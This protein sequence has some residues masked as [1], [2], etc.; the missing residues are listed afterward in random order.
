MTDVYKKG[1]SPAVYLFFICFGRG[2][3]VARRDHGGGLALSESSRCYCRS[4]YDAEITRNRQ[5]RQHITEDLPDAS[6][7]YDWNIYIYIYIYMCVCVC[8]CVCVAFFSIYV[9]MIHV[10]FNFS[11]NR[12]TSGQK[13]STMTDTNC[14]TTHVF[15][16]K[17]INF[18]LCL[19]W[20]MR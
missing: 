16:R 17:I 1:R 14:N 4:W 6:K 13:V 5:W 20:H 3:S 9:C 7:M 18:F 12:N 11:L 15:A 8:V 19:K 2:T 10:L